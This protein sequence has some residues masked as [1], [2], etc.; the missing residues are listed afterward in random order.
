MRPQR[1]G[2]PGVGGKPLRLVAELPSAQAVTPGQGQTVTV[3]GVKIGSI[4]GVELV[5]GR[6]RVQLDID[7][8]YKTMVRTDA[9][10]LLRPRTALKDMF[11][12]LDPGRRS[13]PAAEKG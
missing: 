7:P 4:A 1:M 8:A 3:A 11:L 6:A 2:L 13:A 10:A 9:T 12:E 5:D